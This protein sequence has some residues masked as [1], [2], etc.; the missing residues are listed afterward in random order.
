MEQRD[1]TLACKQ[2][3]ENAVIQGEATYKGDYKR[4]N[5]ASNKLYE[6]ARYWKEH[7]EIAMDV[8]DI[9]MSHENTNVRIWSCSIALD[10]GFK[11]NEATV[12]LTNIANDPSAGILGL[13]AQM[14]LEVRNNGKQ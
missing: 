11:V 14:S 5:K 9:L 4:G 2:F 3:I 8:L 10:I 6:I 12:I 1:V 7:P 13:N